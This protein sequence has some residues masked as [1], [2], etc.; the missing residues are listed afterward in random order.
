M[1]VA[2]KDNDSVRLTASVVVHRTP[3]WQLRRVLRSLAADGVT[4]VT[5]VDNSPDD[6][7]RAVVGESM[8]G[9]EYIRT[10]NRGYGAAH[11]VAIRKA[12]AAG[13]THHL[14]LNPDV[15]WEPGIA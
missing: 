12:M 10:A 15:S 1:A 14:V 2:M 5:V 13:A 8:T 3:A 9:A 4:A 6:R 11:N 7:L